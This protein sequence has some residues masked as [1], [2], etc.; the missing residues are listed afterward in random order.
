VRLATSE[1][2]AVGF[3]QRLLAPI[4]ERHPH[5][6]LELTT[7]PKAVDLLK[8][9][10]DLAVRVGPHMRPQQQTLV[11]RRLCTFGMGVYVAESYV[12]RHGEPRLDD[13]LAGHLVCAYGDELASIPQAK[14][15]DENASAGRVVLRANS[16]LALAQSIA[17][18]VGVGML[19]CFLGDPLPAT[20][21]LNAEP[22]A[23]TE[24]WL[25][26]TQEL[27]RTARVRAVID[28]LVDAIAL[29]EPALRGELTPPRT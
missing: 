21:R 11:A 15:T 13:R 17:A 8:R 5:I 25:V 2:L 22:L 18:G 19:P 16:M 4:H 23:P 7:G 3:L 28:F 12:A 9:E 10:A 14:W 6:T 24:A 20:R 1:N 29:H 26:V 27:A